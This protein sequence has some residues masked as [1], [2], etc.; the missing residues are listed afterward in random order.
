MHPLIE[1]VTDE[2]LWFIAGLDY[3]QKQEQY[4]QALRELIF[5]RKARFFA[6]DHELYSLI[7]L[8]VVSI[9]EGHERE[10]VICNLLVI[11]AVTTGFDTLTEMEILL[12]NSNAPGLNLPSDLAAVLFEQHQALWPKFSA[13]G[14]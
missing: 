8:G 12:S 13:G 5:E 9:T 6:A 10:F 2:E 3:G 4:F 14:S 7:R 11:H 1:T